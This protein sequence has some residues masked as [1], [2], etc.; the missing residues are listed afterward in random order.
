VNIREALNALDEMK[1]QHCDYKVGKRSI[2]A[3]NEGKRLF[4]GHCPT[5][6]A[7]NEVKFFI[8]EM[9]DIVHD[10]NSLLRMQSD[11]LRE[12]EE[13]KMRIG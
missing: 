8:L 4:C 11:V 9:R 13:I 2:D 3:I 6:D 12:R 5:C 10:Q 7:L 1:A